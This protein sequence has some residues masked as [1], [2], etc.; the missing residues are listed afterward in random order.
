MPCQGKEFIARVSGM[1]SNDGD[2][3]REK[4]LSKTLWATSRFLSL[5]IA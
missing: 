4:I 1:K 2:L 5:A 3:G